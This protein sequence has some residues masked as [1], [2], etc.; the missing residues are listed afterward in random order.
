MKTINL[1]LAASLFSSSA[2]SEVRTWTRA[3][4]K[5]AELELVETTGVP[6][7]KTGH[8]KMSNGRII[9]LPANGFVEAD[10]ELI[11]SWE[12]APVE[13]ELVAAPS[14][15]DDFLEGNLV[16]LKGRSLK[17]YKPENTPAKYYVFYYT[18][19]WCPPCQRFTPS[20]VDFY[21]KMKPGNDNFEL[22]LITSDSNQNAMEEYAKDKK[23]PWPQL[24]MSKVDK[25]ESEF[26]HGV[27]GI[28]SVIVCDL[29]GEIVSRSTSFSALEELLK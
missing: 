17:R 28:P 13:E 24:K 2:F 16:K 23:M 19:S 21:N 8:F 20:L 11:N 29:K 12:P 14:V 18:A 7:E 6:G 5:T 9:D 4:G 15:F 27:S 1:I 26:Q 10:A 22:V 3:D 25:F